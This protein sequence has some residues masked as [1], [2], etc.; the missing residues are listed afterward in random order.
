MTFQFRLPMHPMPH[1]AHDPLELGVPVPDALEAARAET[2]LLKL[3]LADAR[4]AIEEA[5]FMLSCHE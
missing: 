3:E 5:R 1:V 2:A 4:C